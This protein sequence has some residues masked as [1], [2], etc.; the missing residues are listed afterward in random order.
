MSILGYCCQVWPCNLFATWIFLFI[1]PFNNITG[2]CL[3]YTVKA[4]AGLKCGEIRFECLAR[5]L[6]RTEEFQGGMFYVRKLTELVKVYSM[7]LSSILFF[8]VIHSYSWFGVFYGKKMCQD[9]IAWT[10]ERS[11]FPFFN[12][13]RSFRSSIGSA[14]ACSIAV[15]QRVCVNLDCNS[16]STC[17]CQNCKEKKQRPDLRSFKY[18]FPW[19]KGT[20]SP[21]NGHL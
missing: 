2:I 5:K 9:R 15:S 14:E 11:M 16:H 10:A 13:Y 19:K 4:K 7:R 17:M 3:W 12:R 20:L 21:V 8:T 18:L 6:Q 1:T